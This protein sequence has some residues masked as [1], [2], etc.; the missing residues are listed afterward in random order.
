[1]EAD[2][3]LNC[4]S[5]SLCKFFNITHNIL[6]TTCLMHG[7]VKHQCGQPSVQT[8][9]S[10]SRTANPQTG[11]TGRCRMNSPRQNHVQTALFKQMNCSGNKCPVAL[12]QSKIMSLSNTFQTNL[13]INTTPIT[14]LRRATYTTV[15][16]FKH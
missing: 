5:Y 8:H 15:N 12:Y 2:Q 10:A 4:L 3:V 11:S 1:M 6:K 9:V 14:Q 13:S 16:I 7:T